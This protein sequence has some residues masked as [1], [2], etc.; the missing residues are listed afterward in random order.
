MGKGGKREFV[1]ALRLLESFRR[2]DVVAGI[3]AM[4]RGA[5]GFDVVKHLELCRIERRRRSS[6]RRSIP[7]PSGDRGNGLREDLHGP[8]HRGD[9]MSDTPKVADQTNHR[10]RRVEPSTS[11]LACP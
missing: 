3:K 4:A 7:S 6:I 10:D 2:D 11:L 8:A 1:Q 5:I 9:V